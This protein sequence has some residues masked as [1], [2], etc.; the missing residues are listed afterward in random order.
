MVTISL[1]NINIWGKSGTGKTKG[2]LLNSATWV[3]M[4]ILRALPSTVWLSPKL[5][6]SVRF[7]YI[8]Y[9]L[10]DECNGSIVDQD[11]KWIHWGTWVA[12]L[13][14]QFLVSAQVMISWSVS[15]SPA[16]GLCCRYEVWSLLGFSL[17]ISLLPSPLNK[18]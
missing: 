12:Q 14:I 8:T 5:P 11:L 10:K 15:S 1:Q 9:S 7:C 16:L 2:F 3:Y 6:I 13:S 18:H 17:F 4:N